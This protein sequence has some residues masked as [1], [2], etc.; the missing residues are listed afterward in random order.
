MFIPMAAEI[1]RV[2]GNRASFISWVLDNSTRLGQS[3]SEGRSH[4]AQDECL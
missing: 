1:G 4:A 3:H 2:C